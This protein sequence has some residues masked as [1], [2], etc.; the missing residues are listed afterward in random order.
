[1]NSFQWIFHYNRYENRLQNK[2]TKE[3]QSLSAN[4]GANVHYKHIRICIHRVEHRF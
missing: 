4:V 1:M 2:S 3:L